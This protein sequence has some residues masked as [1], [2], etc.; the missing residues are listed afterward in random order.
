MFEHQSH[1]VLSIEKLLKN[2]KFNA[3]LIKALF[4]WKWKNLFAELCDFC[5]QGYH[6][7]LKL[8]RVCWLAMTICIERV[9]KPFPSVQRNILSLKTDEKDEMESAT[10]NNRLIAAFKHRLAEAML[11]FLHIA[12]PLLISLNLLLQRS[13]PLI[14]ILYNALFT[15][16]KQ[17]FRRF[18]STELVRKFANY[19]IIIVQMKREVLKDENILDTSKMF[20]GFL[21]RLFLAKKVTSVK[22]SLTSFT[23]PSVTFIAQLLFTLSTISVTGWVFAA[24]K[25][26]EFL[27]S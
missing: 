16:V 2:N 9:M 13:D 21:L 7:I 23:N 14:H 5:D 8:Y 11:M 3:W 19:N 18:L 22:E 10:R 27:W 25:I 26:C 12:L 6:K 15:W 24:H 4:S 20:V 17:L 1:H